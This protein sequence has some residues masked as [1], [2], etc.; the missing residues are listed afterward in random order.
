MAEFIQEKE[1]DYLQAG[2]G[3]PIIFLHGL[4]GTLSNFQSQIDHFS[5]IGYQVT[6]PKLPL[7]TMPLATTSV[8]SLTKFLKSFV[9]FKGYE[10]VV[11]V[12]NS[13]GG[14]IALMFQK[15][16]PERVTGLVLAGSS[17][18]YESAMGNTY[19]RRG[20]RNYIAERVRDVFH[21]KEVATDELIDN[22]FD[23]VSDRNKAIRTLAIS[24]SAIRHNMAEDLPGFNVP[25]CVIWGRQDAVTP[26]EV[27]DKFNELLPQSELYWLDECGHAA[28]MERPTEFNQI[29]AEWLDRTLP[30][31]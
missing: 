18:L 31:A 23:T 19:P 4:M 28:M 30:K 3:H 20:D 21:V 8:K 27:A 26:P 22:V 12:G 14:H 25:V 16:Y 29:V 5:A 24:K 9:D 13:L 1:F 17:G 7:Y 6:V 11:L 10:K 15:M 2:E